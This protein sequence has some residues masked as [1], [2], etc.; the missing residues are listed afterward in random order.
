MQQFVEPHNWAGSA[1]KKDSRANFS[2]AN[3]PGLPDFSCYSLPKRE[4]IP[5]G[6]RNTKWQQNTTNGR[7]IRQMAIK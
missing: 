6:H 7:T 5:N 3:D 4:N 2:G 1:E